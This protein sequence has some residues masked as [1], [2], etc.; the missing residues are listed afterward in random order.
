MFDANATQAAVL[1]ADM[2]FIELSESIKMHLQ[3][4]MLSIFE[5]NLALIILKTILQTM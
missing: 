1:K 4:V 5:R 3:D 2:K